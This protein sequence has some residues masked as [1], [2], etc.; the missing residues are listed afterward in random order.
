MRPRLAVA[1][2]VALAILVPRPSAAQEAAT[3]DLRGIWNERPDGKASRFDAK[4][5]AARGLDPSA[6]TMPRRLGRIPVRYSQ[7]EGSPKQSGTVR[8]GCRLTAGG[9]PE[10]CTVTR[11]LAPLLDEAAL[12]SVATSRYTPLTVNGVPRPALVE[13]SVKFTE[14]HHTM[15]AEVTTMP[16]IA[17][18]RPDASFTER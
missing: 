18:P 15:E 1:S 4:K 11:P 13:L 17:N 2:A 10:D 6:L 14:P 5:A 3:V 7:I 8:I 12:G 16:P 9:L